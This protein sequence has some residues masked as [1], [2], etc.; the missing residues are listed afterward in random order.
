VPQSYSGPVFFDSQC[1]LKVYSVRV[2]VCRHMA[3]HP[4]ELSWNRTTTLVRYARTSSPIPSHCHALYVH[5]V[6]GQFVFVAAPCFSQSYLAT[7]TLMAVFT[8][9]YFFGYSR[10][11]PLWVIVEGFLQVRRGSCHLLTALTLVHSFHINHQTALVPISC[12]CDIRFDH[13]VSY[14]AVFW[15]QLLHTGSAAVMRCDTCVDFGSI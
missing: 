9:F 10:V 15:W 2:C 14:A 6:C 3:V 5:Y 8:R 12:L 11:E 7:A 13:W 4:A 1:G